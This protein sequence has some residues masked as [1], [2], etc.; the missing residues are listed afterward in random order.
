MS[1]PELAVDKPTV[2]YF[3]AL[4]VAVAGLASFFSLG[5]LEDPD[6]T[7]K[8]AVV[9]TAYPGASPEEVELEV[10]DVLEKAIQEMGQLK[11][12]YSTSRAGQS[13]ISVDIKSEYWSDRLPQVWDELR[14]KISDA[15]SLLPPGAGIPSISDDFSLVYGFVMAITG[16]GFDTNQLDDYVDHLRKELALIR[17]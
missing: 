2:T 9:S 11:E 7:V 14:S 5:Q 10:T 3:A 12:I 16:D 17:E 1:L 13:S 6:F 8:T 15:Q 4:L